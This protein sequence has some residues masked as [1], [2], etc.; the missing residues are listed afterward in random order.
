MPG[1]D[2]Q[3]SAP[4]LVIGVAVATSARWDTATPTSAARVEKRRST[5]R[6]V[7]LGMSFVDDFTSSFAMMLPKTAVRL[8]FKF[9]WSGVFRRGND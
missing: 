2:S 9:L 8:F 5:S 7:C 3:C 4:A 6:E 1:A